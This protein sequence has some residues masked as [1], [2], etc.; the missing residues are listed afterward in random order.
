RIHPR[1]DCITDDADTEGVR[2]RDRR[3]QES[4]LLDPVDARHLSVPV[5]RIG[6]SE[7]GVEHPAAR[8]DSRHARPNG[9]L[10]FDQ[11]PVA[12]YES[13]VTDLHAWHISDGVERARNPSEWNA[14]VSGSH[15]LA[16]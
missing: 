10:A 16:H 3:L 9:S 1:N 7:N 12:A 2:D 4:R 5:Q 11:R 8:K 13:D 15:N 6:G 14:E